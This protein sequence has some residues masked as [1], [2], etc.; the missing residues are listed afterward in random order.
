MLIGQTNP[1][2]RGG[3]A[4]GAQTQPCENHK[5]V[6]LLMFK[7]RLTTR[8]NADCSDQEISNPGLWKATQA[9]GCSTP[10]SSVTSSCLACVACRCPSRRVGPVRR[11]RIASQR[12]IAR[13][14]CIA[15]CS[16]CCRC[17]RCRAC[18]GSAAA[19]RV[20]HR[21]SSLWWSRRVHVGN[22]DRDALLA[23]DGAAFVFHEMSLDAFKME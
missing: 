21:R 12:C 11:R 17:H 1:S 8:P 6:E 4:L 18:R 19:F 23:A 15:R 14:S 7:L 5:N 13:R 3:A 10:V 22:F 2:R 9:H 16:A 20:E